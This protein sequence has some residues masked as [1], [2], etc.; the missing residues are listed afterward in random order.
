M[1]NSLNFV[2]TCLKVVDT[3]RSTVRYAHLVNEDKNGLQLLNLLKSIAVVS[4]I[5]LSIT[6]IHLDRRTHSAEFQTERSLKT[7]LSDSC[8]TSVVN[9]GG[10]AH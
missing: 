7:S 4:P 1:K 2:T 3:R 9:F 8:R 10:G 6:S 5:S